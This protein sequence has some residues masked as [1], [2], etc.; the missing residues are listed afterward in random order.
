[1]TTLSRGPYQH[2]KALYESIAPKSSDSSTKATATD[3]EFNNAL[4]LKYWKRCFKSLLPNAYQSNDSTRM[5]LAFFILSA[6][7][8]LG[9][10]ADKLPAKER[11]GYKDWILS[12]QHPITGGFCGSPNHRL[13]DGAYEGTQNGRKPDY[14]PA[15]LTATFFAMLNMNFVGSIT[16]ANRTGMWKWLKTLQRQDGS[17]GEMVTAQGEIYGSRDM[18]ICLCAAAVRWMLRLDPSFGERKG[19]DIDVDALVKH[20]TNSEV[21]GTGP[22]A[23]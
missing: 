18:R 7:D 8:L 17:F 14:E 3:T 21:C 22:M 23:A 5:T 10:G 11:N 6:L 2:G 20:I 12:C 13:P 4:H 16:Q 9:E 1:M 15:S 19:D